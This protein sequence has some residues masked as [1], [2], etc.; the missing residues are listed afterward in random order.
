MGHNREFEVCQTALIAQ[1][2][3]LEV[4]FPS[5]LFDIEFRQQTDVAFLSI[6]ETE[7]EVHPPEHL[8]LYRRIERLPGQG[9][10]AMHPDMNMGDIM[11]LGHG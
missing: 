3:F 4:L 9:N 1:W 6:P 10:T 8:F 7:A 2:R 5:S 11:A